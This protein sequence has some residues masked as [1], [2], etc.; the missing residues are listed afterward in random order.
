MNCPKT[1]TNGR[2]SLTKQLHF[3][4]KSP[5]HSHI[6]PKAR[7]RPILCFRLSFHRSKARE[8]PNTFFRRPI[9]MTK[10]RERP[11]LCF[12]LSFHRSK[13]QKC[14]N[15]CFREPISMAKARERLILCFRLSFQGSKAQKCPNMCFRLIIDAKFKYCP[16]NRRLNPIYLLKICADIDNVHKLCR[17]VWPGYLKPLSNESASSNY[18]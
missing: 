8:C 4:Q 15:T 10:A 18:H 12:R 7:E 14:P 1:M 3:T 6:N 11:S 2:I 16:L 5:H 13:A 9:S 17:P